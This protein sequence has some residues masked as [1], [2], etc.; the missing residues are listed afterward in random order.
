[1][2]NTKKTAPGALKALELLF[3]EMTFV[4]LGAGMSESVVCGYGSVNGALTFVFAQDSEKESGALGRA[5]ARKICELYTL[6]EKSGAPVV[7]LLDGAGARINEG[8]D[9]LDA[10]GRTLSAIGNMSGKVPQIALIDGI[11]AGMSAVI[12]SMFDIVV[13]TEDSSFFIN[14]PIVQRSEGAGKD[15]GSAK[16]AYKNGVVDILCPDMASAI[17]KI[18]DL[19]ML[20][21][22]NNS[23]K[24]ACA[25]TTDSCERESAELESS[26]DA[27]SVIRVLADAD[28]FIELKGGCAPE[29]K[30]GFAL[31]GGLVVGIVATERGAFLTSTAAR[32]AAAF[33]SYAD[34][35]GLPVLTLVD[36]VGTDRSMASENSPYSSE[37]ARLA[38]AYTASSN[39]K[40][41]AVIGKA[42]GS[43]FTLLGSK[44]VGADIVYALPS[45]EI[46]VMDPE[47]AVSFLYDEEIKGSSD[48][49]SERK[50]LIEK[51]KNEKALAAAA[52]SSGIVDGI[53]TAA[54]LRAKLI[55]ALM[56]L[57]EKAE[58]SVYRK[59]TKLPF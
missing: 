14:P 42:Y 46:S 18:R 58:G 32:K 36:T 8:S 26:A 51:W 11:C 7:A 4:E 31:L 55:S 13:A 35:F 17:S 48:P 33:I 28:S 6:A 24:I 30:T 20:L 21:P 23:Q 56:M 50:K 39:V 34:N 19:L 9:A 3:D 15:A 40:I 12:A 44:A 27:A 5:E 37:L 16:N 59:H 41:T 10:F 38:E 1:M 25:E 57:W 53:V 54:E 2:V 43:P 29:L 52:A 45:A 22:Q 49:V 47:A